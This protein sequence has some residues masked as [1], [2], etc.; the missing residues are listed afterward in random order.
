MFLLKFQKE[1]KMVSLNKLMLNLLWQKQLKSQK[2]ANL[3]I[4][5]ML[6]AMRLVTCQMSCRVDS[7]LILPLFVLVNLF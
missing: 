4:T 7:V 3:V 6:N 5:A 1:I 2:L